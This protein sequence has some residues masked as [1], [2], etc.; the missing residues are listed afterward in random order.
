M[1][2]VTAYRT[3]MGVTQLRGL[4]VIQERQGKMLEAC[5]CIR[6]GDRSEAEAEGLVPRG[7]RREGELQR[8]GSVEG[9]SLRQF[10]PEL[11]YLLSKIGRKGI[12]QERRWGESDGSGYLFKDFKDETV[13]LDL[14]ERKLLIDEINLRKKKYRQ[15][16]QSTNSFSCCWKSALGHKLIFFLGSGLM[17][18]FPEDAGD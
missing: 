2:D 12:S 8:D 5:L 11:F 16:Y 9:G 4:L 13:N 15:N 1:A 14:T 7:K 3:L 10:A 17:W 6:G 18:A